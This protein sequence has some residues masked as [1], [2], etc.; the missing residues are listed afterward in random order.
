MC[1]HLKHALECVMYDFVYH[2][3]H[4]NFIMMILKWKCDWEICCLWLHRKLTKSQHYN[5]VIMSARASQII[6]LTIVYS[7]VHSRRRSKKTSKLRATGLCK[8]NSPVIGEFPAQK[9]SNAET[10]S[11]WWR[12]HEFRWSH[13]RNFCKSDISAAVKHINDLSSKQ[14]QNVNLCIWN[15]MVQ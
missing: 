8:G 15:P 9:A 13:W 12:H 6:S 4:C 7:T 1:V 10:V 3:C 2:I 14:N 5:D 11:I